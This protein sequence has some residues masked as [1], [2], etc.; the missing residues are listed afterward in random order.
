MHTLR[1][2]LFIGCLSMAV[3]GFGNGVGAQSPA[4]L[5]NVQW[6]SVA[7]GVW[8]ASVGKPDAYNLTT[9]LSIT[10][11]IETI[12]RMESAQLPLQMDEISFQLIDGKT[13]IRFPLDKEEQIYGLGLNFK[14][15]EQRGSILRLHMDHYAG[16]DNGRNH[17]PVPFFVSSKGYG[18]F[19]NSARYI[20]CWVGTSVR[21]DSKNPPVVRD[22]NTDPKWEAQPYSDNLE[23]LVPAEGVE[24]TLF[25][26]KNMLDV[27]RR[28]NLMNGGGTLPPKWGLGF[29]QRVGSLL[30][31]KEVETEVGDFEKRGYP[32]SVIGLEPGWQS[33]SYPCSYEWD[34]TR[35]PNPKQFVQGLDA[36]KVKVNVW[37]NPYIAPKTKLYDAL[38][39]FSASHTVWCG[40]VPDYSMDTVQAIVTKHLTEQ[41]VNI[42]VMG[43]KLDENDGYDSWLW[44]DV[45]TFPS[46]HPAEQ[47]RQVYGSLIQQ[48]AYRMYHRTNHRTYG[49]VRAG[50]AGT[51]SFPFVLYNDYYDHHDY[52]TALINSSFIGVLWTPEVRSSKTA[53]EW[54][55]RMQ[56]VCFSPLAML[57]AWADKTKPWSFAEVNDQISEVMHLRMQLIPYLYTAFADYTFEGIPPFRAM[58]LED[59]FVNQTTVEAG[60]LDA[61]DNPY[62]MARKQEMKDQYMVGPDLLVAPLF[63][64]DTVRKVVLPKGKWYDFYTGKFAG[65]SEVITVAPGLKEIPVFVRDGGIVPLAPAVNKMTTDRQPLEVRCYGHKP[66]VYNLY[67]DDGD[68]YDYEQGAFARIRLET[69]LKKGK[70]QGKVII[71][72]GAKTWSFSAYNFRFMT[73]QEE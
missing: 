27:V 62:A 33:C 59:G 38:E 25:A 52:I 40:I 45:A 54:L 72:K 66:S 11:R 2:K 57:D 12:N 64:G 55:R 6:T 69:S 28:F 73:E 43:V 65:E 5:K 42:G 9:G 67:D 10:P 1:L 23:F 14:K 3:A 32:L 29:W 35:F 34:K 60:K 22:R 44:P 20:D 16:K 41:L 19:I 8:K 47:M 63:A 18:A 71:P 49:L 58:S 13:Y 53:E 51:S 50:N 7:S 39:P 31:D 4:P 61:T 36:K 56:T 30:T 46:R 68:S 21:K 70:L 48:N 15:V 17:A 37:M 26:G 24:I